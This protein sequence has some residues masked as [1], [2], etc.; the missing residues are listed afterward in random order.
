MRPGIPQ[1]NSH[2]KHLPSALSLG[3]YPDFLL[4]C[5]HRRPRMWFSSK[6]TTRSRSKPQLSTGNP[7]R[8]R[9]LRFRGPENKREGTWTGAPRSPKRTWA[10]NDGRSPTIAF[11]NV[12][13]RQLPSMES[14]SFPL[15]SRAADSLRRV[16][17]EMTRAKS[18]GAPGLAFETW[19]PS[20]QFLLETPALLFVIR[21]EAEICSSADP[22]W[23]HLIQPSKRI[24]I[25][26][27]A[28]RSGEICG[29]LLL[30][31]FLK[32]SRV[33]V[34][35]QPVK[36]QPA[37]VRPHSPPSNQQATSSKDQLFR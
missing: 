21:S 33:R 32:R 9:D 23:K 24:V 19:D 6:R 18:K 14:L 28:Q 37:F 27:G 29:S 36:K 34:R 26:T 10:E 22:S 3:A 2:W 13:V 11:K 16:G 1:T 30:L 17:R 4:H 20:N 7:G 15:S 35:Q 8:P 31:T 5:S 12:S 25:S